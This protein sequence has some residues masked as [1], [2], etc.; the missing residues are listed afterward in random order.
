[1][2]SLVLKPVAQIDAV[3]LVQRAVGGARCPARHDALDRLGH[4]LDVRA[5]QR[6]QEVPS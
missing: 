5:L 6:R 3:E 2:K 1:M 4:E